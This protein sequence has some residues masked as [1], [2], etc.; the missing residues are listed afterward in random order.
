[1]AL[2]KLLNEKNA[3]KQRII[4]LSGN[5]QEVKVLL[6]RLDRIEKQIKALGG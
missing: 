6:K 1:M 4:L 5:L 2:G 3:I